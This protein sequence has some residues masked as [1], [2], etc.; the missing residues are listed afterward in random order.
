MLH[1]PMS[2]KH[3]NRFFDEGHAT[4]PNLRQP[5]LNYP[6]ARM[7]DVVE[8]YHGTPVADPYRWLEDTTAPETQAWVAAQQ[9]L[10]QAFLENIPA[11][12]LIK[13]RLSELWNYPRLSVPFKAGTRY[14]FTRNDGLQNQDVLYM[15]Q[16]LEGEPI[17][18]LN[19]NHLSEDGTVALVNQ[20]YSHDGML[21]AYGLSRHGSDWQEIRVRQIDAGQD[22]AEVLQ[23]CKFTRLAWT[24][25]NAGFF[26]SGYA[27]PG[28][29]PAPADQPVHRLYWHTVGTPQADDRLVY[30]RPDRPELH[31][32]PLISEDGQ[33]IVLYVWHGAIPQNRIYYRAVHHDGTFIRLL[34]DADA[35]YAFVGNVG[36]VCYFLTNLHAPQGRIIAIDLDHP[37][38]EHWREILPPQADVIDFARLI[39]DQLTVVFMHDA[40]HQLKLY[41]RDGVF[42]RTITLPMPGS[43]V[44]IS[45]KCDE[46]EMF[47]GVQAFLHPTTIVRYDFTADALHPFHR[48]ALSF[49]ASVYETQQVFYTSTDGTRVP[50]FLTHRK[51]LRRDGEHPTLLYGYG[52]FAVNLTPFFAASALV[53]L[54]QGGIFAVANLRGGSEYG[55]AWHQAGMLANKPQVFDDFIAAA[56]W[57]IRERYTSSDQLAILGRSNG[58]LLVAACMLQRPDLFGAVVCGVPVTDMLRYHRFT[59]GRFWVPEYG[60]AETDPEHFR[61]LYAYSPLHN[62]RRGVTYPPTLITTGDTDDRV[63]PSHALKFAA[64]LQAADAGQHPILLRVDIKAG[65]G[66]GKP[67]AKLLEEQAD[68]Y[69]FLCHTL[70]ITLSNEC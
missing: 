16:G 70:R 26:Y 60:N 23:W 68:I 28:G 66:L 67:V 13:A 41:T 37:A 42:V 36:H 48:P 29:E 7:D 57:L 18:I 58:G 20:S 64:T 63:V 33:Y 24:H 62:V 35:Y 39:N 44:G 54:E 50:M 4:M 31:F 1:S 45:G 17:E 51:G 11:R 61:F 6:V 34:D 10:T 38:R 49:D 8:N 53:W 3:N 25:D 2:H 12:E 43:I 65:H 52:G 46:P 15:Q 32:N 27:L 14:F 40:Q 5:R 30:E 21:L 69:A 59:A 56:E 19:P 55:E 47:V 9:R 22:H